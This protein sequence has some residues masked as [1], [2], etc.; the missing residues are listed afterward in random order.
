MSYLEYF[1]ISILYFWGSSTALSFG[2]GY[3]TL[4]RPV[5]SGLLTGFILGDAV[6]G[7]AAGAVVNLIYMNFIST[8]GSFKGDQ[9]L[10]AIIAAAAAVT[11]NLNMVESAAIAYPFGFLGILIW[12]YRLNINSVF[13]KKFEEEYE[14]GNNPEINLYNGFLPQLLLYIMSTSVIITALFIMNSIGIYAA[15]LNK[16]LFILGFALIIYTS[17]SLILK[18]KNKKFILIFVGSL[19]ITLIFNIPSYLTVLTVLLFLFLYTDKT[20]IKISYVMHEQSILNKRDLVY[21]WVIWSNYS[22]SC[23]SFER[24]Q[25]LAFAHSMKNIFRKLYNDKDEM[26]KGIYRHSEFF[27]TEPNMGTPIIGYIISQEEQMVLNKEENNNISFVKKGMMGIAAGLGDSFTQV[28]LT[29]MFISLSVVLC[30]DG[31]YSLAVIP[32]IIL[33]L[34][35]LMISYTGFMK[36]YY[37]GKE[38]LIERINIVKNSKIKLYFPYIFSGILGV[39]LGKLILFNYMHFFR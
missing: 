37:E 4:Y 7:M 29:P 39:S 34:L 26:M 13:V 15:S 28:V 1:L 17:C 22:H 32:V 5:I 3:F 8:G 11:L 12:K 30:T 20:L 10:T 14:K 19:I 38:S 33:A 27:N 6:N 24:L 23:Y 21:S 36:G 16:I 2:V 18:L 35:I 25:G 9:M 31:Y